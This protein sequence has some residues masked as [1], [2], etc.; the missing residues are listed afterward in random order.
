MSEDIQQMQSV[1]AR[2]PKSY[3][4]RTR[5]ID[6]QTCN[7]YREFSEKTGKRELLEKEILVLGRALYYPTGD[8]IMKKRALVILSH[9]ATIAGLR[10]IEEYYKEAD[11]ELKN[12]ALLALNECINFMESK[13]E[14]L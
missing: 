5:K 1:L 11:N 4:S 9:T 3:K 6:T 10:E 7:E 12:W 8:A 13:V 2:L 14:D